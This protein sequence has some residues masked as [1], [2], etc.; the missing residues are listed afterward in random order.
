MKYK[1]IMALVVAVITITMAF[2][3]A[4]MA[5]T[6]APYNWSSWPQQS[7]TSYSTR[8]TYAIQRFLRVSYNHYNILA[9][10]LGHPLSYYYDGLVNSS[11]NVDG[12]YGDKT[13]DLV[14][15]FQTLYNLDADGV[16]GTNTWAKMRSRIAVFYQGETPI[17]GEQSIQTPYSAA[18]TTSTRT[19]YYV[20]PITTNPNIQNDG[21]DD[22]YTFKYV[23]GRWLVNRSHGSSFYYIYD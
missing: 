17:P 9:T 15:H 3:P 1:K 18:S 10:F 19:Y 22:S 23:S 11:G 16:V 6:D 8:Y 13:R 12:V 5:Q 14:K 21:V 4:A 2:A 7:K 20:C